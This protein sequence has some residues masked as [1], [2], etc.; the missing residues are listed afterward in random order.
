MLGSWGQS[1]SFGVSFLSA[2]PFVERPPRN[3]KSLPEGNRQR[4]KEYKNILLKQ[5][6]HYITEILLKYK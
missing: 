1:D 6:Y 2:K 3:I 5:K 4:W